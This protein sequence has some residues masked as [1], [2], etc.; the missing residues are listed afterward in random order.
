VGP[1]VFHAIRRVASALAVA[2]LAW[3]VFEI[4][5]S[6]WPAI[7]KFGLGFLGSSRGFETARFSASFRSLSGRSPVHSIAILFAFPL[8]LAIAIFLS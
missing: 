3:I 1:D 5:S 7:L 6:A 2:T 4:V 8:G